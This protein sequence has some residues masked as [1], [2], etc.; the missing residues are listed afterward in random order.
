LRALVATA[1]AG[2]GEAGEED[3]AADLAA[4]AAADVVVTG[5]GQPVLLPAAAAHALRGAVRAALDNVRRHAGE[6]ATAWVLLEDE[7]DRV[8]VTVRDDGAGIAPGRLEEAA[9]EGRLGVQASLRGRM[10]EVGGTVAVSSAPGQGTEV[11]LLVPKAPVRS[12]ASALPTARG[13]GAR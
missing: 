8:T 9:R 10:A 4:L 1:P 13:G 5:P 6:G 2:A 11:E 7:P 3:L 12:K